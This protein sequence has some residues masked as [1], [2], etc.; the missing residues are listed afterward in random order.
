VRR[1]FW[2]QL[3]S[4]PMGDYPYA[5]A[6]SGRISVLVGGYPASRRRR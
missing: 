6:I 1:S 5:P 4:L 2:F 3:A